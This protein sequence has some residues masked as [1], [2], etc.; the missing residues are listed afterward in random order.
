VSCAECSAVTARLHRNLRVLQRL[1]DWYERRDAVRMAALLSATKD[2]LAQAD[3]RPIDE[4]RAE[5]EEMAR[6]WTTRRDQLRA[7]APP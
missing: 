7:E 1:R 6:L 2:A 3:S 4:Q 5:A